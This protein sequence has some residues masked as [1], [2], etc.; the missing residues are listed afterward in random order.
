MGYWLR[1]HE[2]NI[3]NFFILKNTENKKILAAKS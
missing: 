3:L 2:K 1:D